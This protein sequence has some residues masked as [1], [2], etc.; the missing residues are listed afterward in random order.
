MDAEFLGSGFVLGPQLIVTCAHVLQ[1]RDQFRIE[2]TGQSL[3][4]RCVARAIASKAA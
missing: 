2:C 1:G 4:A 3:E